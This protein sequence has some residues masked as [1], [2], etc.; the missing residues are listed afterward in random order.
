[1]N[2][3]LHG[4]TSFVVRTGRIFSLVYLAT[5]TWLLFTPRPFA[6]LSGSLGDSAEHIQAT[7]S[8]H[9]L[10]AGAFLLLSLLL[11]TFYRRPTG[12]P[13]L[14]LVFAI[15]GYGIVAEVAHNWIPMRSFQ[16]SDLAAN[17]AGILIGSLACQLLLSKLV[18]FKSSGS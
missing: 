11:L 4:H 2:E 7:V 18:L 14:C 17:L 16:W 5:L 12:G 8:D 9:V 13:R 10:H 1:M 3:A 15:T 6:I